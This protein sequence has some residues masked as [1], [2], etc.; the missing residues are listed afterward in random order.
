MAE[1]KHDFGKKERENFVA[2]LDGR[3]QSEEPDENRALCA[4]NFCGFW[5]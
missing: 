5:G 1:D 4:G 3:N 2:D